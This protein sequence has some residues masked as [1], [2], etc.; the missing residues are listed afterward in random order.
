[1]IGTEM[2]SLLCLALALLP[3][4][5]AA[6]NL[7]ILRMPTAAPPPG[8]A[9]SILIP[10]RNEE[11]GIEG[12]VRVALASTGVAIEV[13]VLDDHSEDRT[14]AIVEGLAREDDRVRLER[15][16]PLPPGWS[17][18]QHACHVLGQRAAHDVLMFVDADVRLA[19]GAAAA[20]RFL[21]SRE[22]GLASGFPREATV[23][24]AK[25]LIIPMI[26]LL[27]LGYLPMALMRRREDIGL[28]AGCG[29]FIIARKDAYLQAG[30]H[31]AI[32]RSLHDGLM[33][34]RAFRRAGLRTDLFDATT[35][36]SCR[37][38]D[39][40]RAVWFG[41]SKNATEG[42][43]TPRALPVWTTLLLAGHVLPWI[44]LPAALALGGSPFA[45]GCFAAAIGANLLL[46]GAL[47]WRFWQDR[48]SVLCH[49]LA[50]LVM[51][52]LQWSALLRGRSGKP[53]RS[54]PA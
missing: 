17:G 26:H 22:V 42:M 16:P 25:R 23:T 33:L 39:G 9:V 20:S 54:Y 37:M 2:I 24:F 47:A 3:L 28:G 48:A 6:W 53:G 52:A 35:L 19:P 44:G 46:R 11:K 15:A 36:A 31:A 41:L 21:L 7:A 34:P 4:G 43:A 5:L 18:K 50:M 8:T 10:A 40:A 30:G 14:T 38:Y 1:M 27:L 13:V 12:A 32:R 51:L 45:A 29:Q 49:P